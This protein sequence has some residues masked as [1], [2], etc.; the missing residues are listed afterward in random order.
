MK[1]AFDIEKALA[2]LGM[3][4]DW[5]SLLFFLLVD[6]T[7]LSHAGHAA[8]LVVVFFD[9]M[10]QALCKRTLDIVGQSMV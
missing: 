2:W 6:F 1:Y 5:S 7:L 4:D 3:I 8:D 9:P 10:G